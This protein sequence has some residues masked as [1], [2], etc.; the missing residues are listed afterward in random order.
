MFYKFYKT[1]N[2]SL[3][4]YTQ[5][6]LINVGGKRQLM[7]KI[8]LKQYLFINSALPKALEEKQEPRKYKK[9]NSRSA[10]HKT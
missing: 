1:T 8:K 10:N 7:I 6:N 2:A 3:E 9:N 5:Q 4:Y